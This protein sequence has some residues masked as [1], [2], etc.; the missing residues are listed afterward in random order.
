[1]KEQ[2]VIGSIWKDANG[3]TFRVTG[4]SKETEPWITLRRISDGVAFT[5]NLSMFERSLK[6]AD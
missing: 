2:I 5:K 6:P 3:E 1:M 4:V